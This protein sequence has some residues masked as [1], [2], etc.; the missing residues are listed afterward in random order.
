[1]FYLHSIG[2]L[3]DFLNCMPVMS[4]LHKKYGK[5]NFFVTHKLKQ[6]KGFYE[7]MMYQGIFNDVKFDDEMMVPYGAIFINPWDARE[8]KNNP[9]R[10][11]ETCRFENNLIDRYKI[12][13]DVDDDFTI[14]FP[15][16]NLPVATDRNYV[17]DRWSSPNI[18]TRR[19]T[20]V[21]EMSGMFNDCVWL[22]YNTDLLTNCY[23]IHKSPLP[24][25]TTFTGI[26]ILADLLK[27]EMKV[28][29]GDDLRNWDNKTIEYSYQKHFYQ[30]RKSELIYIGD[31]LTKPD[32][33]GYN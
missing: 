9:M 33:R 28:F 16:R 15:D 30:D 24:L 10:P 7:F 27:K 32:D 2:N 14:K 12:Q 3:G 25:Y 1:M 22:D 4:G 26:S 31:W 20:R 23:Y 13:F 6:F 5:L 19:P 11:L 29:W 18:D 8:D 17:G 21:L